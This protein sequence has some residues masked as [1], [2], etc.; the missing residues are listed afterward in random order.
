MAEGGEKR[1]KTGH[2]TPSQVKRHG[3]TFQAQPEQIA[4][5]S[6]RNKARAK[7]KAAG[8][9]VAGKDVAHKKGLSNAR[10][11]LKV[12]SKAANRGHGKTRGAKANR[13]TK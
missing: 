11:N 13:G 8:V 5:R 4:R 1:S 10:S 9:K 2:R 3:R 6:Q 12:Q 7:L